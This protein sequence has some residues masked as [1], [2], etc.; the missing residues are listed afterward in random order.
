MS[1]GVCML[2]KWTFALA[3]SSLQLLSSGLMQQ[4]DVYGLCQMA[5]RPQPLHKTRAPGLSVA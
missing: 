3:E 2:Q 1:L 5:I 4:I